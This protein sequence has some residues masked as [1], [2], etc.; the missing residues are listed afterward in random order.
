MRL[1]RW[2]WPLFRGVEL[3]HY[4]LGSFAVMANHVQ[5]LLFPEISPGRLLKLLQAH[6][7]REANRL[8]GRTGEPFWQ[9]K[10]YDPSPDFSSIPK[11]LLGGVFL[12]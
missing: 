11:P 9:R 2:W 5:V 10:S 4:K 7:A 1:L 6:T 3:G 8:L 12:W